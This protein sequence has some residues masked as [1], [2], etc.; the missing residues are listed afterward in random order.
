MSFDAAGV[1]A[2][3]AA[4][5]ALAQRA[6]ENG[7]AILRE[8]HEA[9]RLP[10]D[11]IS[12]GLGSGAAAFFGSPEGKAAVGRVF[13]AAWDVLRGV[14]GGAAAATTAAAAAPTPRDAAAA[15]APP[16]VPAPPAAQAGPG[17]TERSGPLA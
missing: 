17:G 16:P 6:R 3:S 5:G 12:R 7:Q 8:A 11:R 1:R 13:A 2:A 15:Q 10:E 4:F 14:F 9:C